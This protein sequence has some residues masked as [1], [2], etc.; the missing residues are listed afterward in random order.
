MDEVFGFDFEQIHYAGNTPYYNLLCC[1]TFMSIADYKLLQKYGIITKDGKVME[2]E[3]PTY[4]TASGNVIRKKFD[5]HYDK[6]YQIEKLLSW[7]FGDSPAPSSLKGCLSKINEL[8]TK[9]ESTLHY[10]AVIEA[11]TK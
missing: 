3:W 4:E 8:S 5:F 11:L 9:K 7:I 6:K 2:E 10:D 1:L